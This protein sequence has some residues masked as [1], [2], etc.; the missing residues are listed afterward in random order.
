MELGAKGP[1]RDGP[2]MPRCGAFYTVRWAVGAGRIAVANAK[3]S[4]SNEEGSRQLGIEE[5]KKLL[6]LTQS[7]I[8]EWCRW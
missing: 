8:T 5:V 4:L 2:P 1:L 3:M 7:K 6:W